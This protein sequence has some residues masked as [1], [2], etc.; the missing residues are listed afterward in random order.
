MPVVGAARLASEVY[1][2]E[3]SNIRW[4]VVVWDKDFGGASMDYIIP[5]ISMDLSYDSEADNFTE[6]LKPS[7]VKLVLGDT[8]SSDFT[9]FKNDLATAQE[10]EFKLIIYKHNGTNFYHYWAGVIMTD[11]V[12]WDDL[13]ASAVAPRP[14]EIVAKDGLNR[15]ANFEFDKVDDSPYIV[16]GVTTPQSFFQVIFDCLSYTDTAQFWQGTTY[17]NGNTYMRVNTTWK[18]ANMVCDNSTSAKLQTRSLEITRIDRDFMFDHY[19]DIE[20]PSFKYKDR[21]NTTKPL[22]TRGVNDPALKTKVVL[23]DLLQLVGLRLVLSDG[24]WYLTQVATYADTTAKFAQYDYTGAFTSETAAIAIQRTP[25]VLTGGK[26][27]YFPSLRTARASTMPTDILGQV[28]AGAFLSTDNTL[29]E[30]TFA[31]GT[32]YGGTGLRLRVHLPIQGVNYKPKYGDVKVEITITL[33]CGSYRVTALVPGKYDG[34]IMKWTTT[35]TDK[36]E[37]KSLDSHYSALGR[38]NNLYAE[39]VLETEDMPFTAEEDCEITVKVELTRDSGALPSAANYLL[40]LQPI[41]IGVIDTGDD[42]FGKISEYVVVNPD[43]SPGNSVDADLGKLNIHDTGIVTNKV[44]IETDEYVGAGRWVKSTVWDAGHTTDVSL[45]QTILKEAMSLQRT[46]IK[47]YTG[48]FRDNTWS[49]SW[50]PWNTLIYD[51]TVWVFQGVR[52]NFHK[53]EWDG[54]WFAINRSITS[55]T[56]ED[57]I[58]NGDVT[59]QTN[60]IGYGP[61]NVRPINPMPARPADTTKYPIVKAVLNDF[62]EDGDSISGIAIDA[63]EY[64]HL[65]PGD[66]ITIVDTTTGEAGD[67]LTV[68]EM[69]NLGDTSITLLPVTLTK[70]I[71]ANSDV[72]VDANKLFISDNFRAASKFQGGDYYN[73]VETRWLKAYTTSTTTTE[74]TTDGATGSGTDNRIEV[75]FDGSY[76]CIAHILAKKESAAVA[77]KWSREFI[78]TNNGGTTALEGTVQ[79]FGTDIFDA[80]LAAITITISAN[81]TND[82]IKIEVNGL[83]LTTINWT[84]RVDITKAVY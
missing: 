9:S 8:G 12:E 47:K 24:I 48:C 72:S 51:S 70:D 15:A 31:L 45:V 13:P 74:L 29:Y 20:D 53:N 22:R 2:G 23:S 21:I 11:L 69:I 60:P 54:V 19:Q 55:I 27:G 79:N 84:A 33:V 6:P 78:M 38:K 50:N 65:W 42:N 83:A 43:L 71:T 52:Y 25:I 46:P 64:S 82:C 77:G 34:G 76:Y 49:T 81:N 40:E 63:S 35:S 4:R 67:D 32:L 61:W 44:S 18:D 58:K 3:G 41:S 73:G 30:E 66:I 57:V 59:N 14:F 26:F 5:V 10:D 39:V 75:P 62:G 68:D 36:Y 17:G 16:A 56:D 80:T 1:S 37:Y 7:S 28:H